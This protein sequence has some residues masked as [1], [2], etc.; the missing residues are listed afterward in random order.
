MI[1]YR[2]LQNS[3]VLQFGKMWKFCVLSLMVLFQTVN[4]KFIAIETICDLD[5]EMVLKLL[6]SY[7]DDQ[8]FMTIIDIADM[9]YHSMDSL[10]C[11]AKGEFFRPVDVQNTINVNL[12][13]PIDN[14]SVSS[15]PT[16]HGYFVR[17]R[18]DGFIEGFYEK[19]SKY[20]P[21]AKL[22]INVMGLN[23]A[24]AKNLLKTGFEKFG[25]L[26]VASL[27]FTPLF[28]NGGIVV[29]KITLCM[30]NPFNES[31]EPLFGCYRFTPENIEQNLIDMEKFQKSRIENL[32]QYPLK[33]HI[34]E[35]DMKSVAVYDENGK[36]THYTYPDGELVTAL[37]KVMNFTPVFLPQREGDARYGYQLGNGTFTGGLAASEYGRADLVANPK[38][39]ANYNTEKSVFLRP[40]TMTKL[41]FII[42][43]RVTSKKTIISIFSELDYLSKIFAILL[44]VLFPL[45]YVAT[46]N[47]E[48]HVMG[49]IHKKDITKDL[50]YVHGLQNCIS[51]RHTKLAASR[52][53]VATILFYVLLSTSLFQGSIVKNLNINSKIGKIT[54]IDQ[55]LEQNFK[56]AMQPVLTYA[57][58]GQGEDKITQELNRMSRNFDEIALPHHDA[59]ARLR[60][61]DKFAYLWIDAVTG[62]Y[63]DRYFDEANG[64]NY[65]EVVPE[66]AFEFYIAMMAPK[67]SP[68]VDRFNHIL[69]IY[70]QTGLHQY[71]ALKAS[72]DNTKVWIQRVKKGMIP[73]QKTRWLKVEDLHDAF[74]LYLE[75]C[76]LSFVVFV[77]EVLIRF[78]TTH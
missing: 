14:S 59:F 23:V 41:F 3:L 29:F 24:N 62:N 25:M 13:P 54:K 18:Q 40:M 20:N 51:L 30:F 65:L 10:Q 48:M 35:Y 11:L 47:V 39:I 9:S 5:N 38:L 17:C 45:T 16:T 78:I 43:K 22:M 52:I 77:I 15:Y 44:N 73:K 1:I 55:L 64:E 63:L 67:S 28:Q 8:H 46:Y 66:S 32:Q 34:F 74:I 61:D 49:S 2:R 71:H 69:N 57:F 4:S 58:Q 56:I 26:N 75:F 53:V 68:F 21:R 76:A 7:F 31:E 60:K 70:V 37:A 72:D 6:F 36:I 33:I 27:S 12:G 42:R 19:L 50:L